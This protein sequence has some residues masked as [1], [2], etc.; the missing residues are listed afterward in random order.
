[1]ARRANNKNNNIYLN[2]RSNTNPYKSRELVEEQSEGI[3]NAKRLYD[4]EKGN[5]SPYPHEVLKM[6]QIYKSS[7][8]INYYCTEECPIGKN[9]VPKVESIHDLP[10]ITLDLLAKLNTLNKDKDKIIEIA[11]DGIIGEDEKEEFILF[12]KHLDE[13]SMAIESLKLWAIKKGE[14]K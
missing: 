10:Q 13:M 8:L 6:A 5:K 2:H 3:I 4:I 14:T 11:S 12:Q 9:Y 7:E 1:M